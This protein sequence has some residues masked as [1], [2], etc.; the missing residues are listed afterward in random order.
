MSIKAIPIKGILSVCVGLA[1]AGFLIFAATPQARAQSV[2]ELQEQINELLEL[3]ESLEAQLGNGGGVATQCNAQFLRDLSIGST[4]ADV[5]ALQQFLNMSPDTRVAVAG[6]G[7]PG[8]ETQYYGQLTAAAVSKFQVKYR[9]EILTPVGLVNPTGYFGAMSRAQ[10]NDLCAGGVVDP[11]D[12][13]DTD[14]DTDDNEELEGGEASLED[15]NGQDGEDTNLEEGQEN[16]PVAEFEF[17][18]EDGDVRIER[19]DL[20]FDGEGNEEE[21][22]WDAFENVSIW[23]DGDEIA[24]VDADDEDQWEEDTPY[25][26]AHRIRLN[27]VDWVIREGETAEFIVAVTVGGSVDGAGTGA[28]DWTVFV[29]E[30]G[31]RAMDAAGLDQ[32]TGEEGSI[33]DLS[34][35]DEGVTFDI[36][37]EGGDDE[38]TVSSSN[39]DPEATTLQLEEND[40]SDWLTV[41]AFDLDAEDSTNDIEIDSLPVDVSVSA[42]TYDTYVN[43]ARLVIDGEEYDDFTVSN[44]NTQDATL[45]FEF[46]DGELVIGEDEVATAVLE[47]E[48]KALD[49]ANE[50]TTIEASVDGDLIEAEGADDL[51]DSQIGGTA[52]SETH[53]LRTSGV[54]LDIVSVEESVQDNTDDSTADDEGIFTIEFEVTAFEEDVFINRTADR[55]TTTGTAG[56]N[57]IIE[58]STGDAVATGTVSGAV[59]TSSADVENSRFVVEEGETETFTLTVEYDPSSSGFYRLQLYSFNFNDTDANPDTYQRALPENDYETD[60]VSI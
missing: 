35:V 27:D 13:D 39:E 9:A 19:I 6:A 46:D 42:D 11:G 57:Y 8:M 12:D 16:A 38:L 37:E 15:F 58:D 45:T 29:D 20:V 22:P 32:Y 44:G 49:E 2:E 5:L 40:Q 25:S 4:G 21:D 30:D 23:V 60:P 47:L 10:A 43:D 52:S 17:D 33:N 50:G 53:T 24:S 34:D 7:S 28:A 51:D 36:G 56:V 48:F 1:M 59:L 14:D 54:T 26:G 41:F 31:I 18:V 3:I 55:G